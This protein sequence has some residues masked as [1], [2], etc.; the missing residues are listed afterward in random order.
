M[1]VYLLSIHLLQR[2]CKAE[3]LRISPQETHNQKSRSHN[4]KLEQITK[5]PKVPWLSDSQIEGES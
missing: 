1:T 3:R 5:S 4:F 2:R